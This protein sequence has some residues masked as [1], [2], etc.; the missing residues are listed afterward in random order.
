MQSRKINQNRKLPANRLA[1]QRSTDDGSHPAT[2]ENVETNPNQQPV[3]SHQQ[4]LNREFPQ[5]YVTG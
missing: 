5:T 4:P 3:T 2:L 1:N